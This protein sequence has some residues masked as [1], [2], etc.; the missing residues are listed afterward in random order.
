MAIVLICGEPIDNEH[1][2]I[3]HIG[4]KAMGFACGG[5]M[6]LLYKKWENVFDEE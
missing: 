3:N 5:L 2:F 1:W 4:M 6:L